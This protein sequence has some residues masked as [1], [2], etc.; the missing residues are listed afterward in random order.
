MTDLGVPT[1]RLA[2]AAC[3]VLGVMFIHQG[4]DAI[5]RYFKHTLDE[6][7]FNFENESFPQSEKD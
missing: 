6:D 2:Y 3:S 4:L 1:S 5:A 7:R